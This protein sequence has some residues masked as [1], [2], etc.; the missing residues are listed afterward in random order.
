MYLTVEQSANVI[1]ADI[2]ADNGGIHV[3]HKVLLPNK[4]PACY[5][6]SS[7]NV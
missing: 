4:S 2:R 5:Q 6:P 7:G 1:I 3:I